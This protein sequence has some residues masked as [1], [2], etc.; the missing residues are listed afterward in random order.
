[1]RTGMLRWLALAMGTLVLVSCQHS[2]SVTLKISPVSPGQP[3]VFYDETG[4]PSERMPPLSE[5]ELRQIVGWVAARTSDRIWL[6]RVRPS[7]VYQTRKSVVAYLA[8]D[9]T[10]QRIRIGRAYDIPMSKEE[11][12]FGS[13]WKYAQVS[14][15]DHRFG[16]QF[17]KPSER[18]V[19]FRCPAGM[20]PNSTDGSSMTKEE[21]VAAV[22]CVRQLSNYD[23]RAARAGVPKNVAVP[24]ILSL[25]TLEI[26]RTGRRTYVVL[27]FMHEPEWGHGFTVTLEHTLTGYRIIAWSMWIS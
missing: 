25:P 17:A 13:P 12:G 26:T 15:K 22:D 20:D 5:V 7:T 1:M 21:V 27:G 8:P 6:I 9:E 16:D 14:L 23:E 4:D 18:E 24:G 11:T 10:T 2:Q 19:P 3:F